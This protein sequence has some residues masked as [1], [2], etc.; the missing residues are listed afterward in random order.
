MRNLILISF[1]LLFGFSQAQT[2][3]FSEDF[4]TLPLSVSSSGS[5]NWARTSMLQHN[6]TYSDSARITGTND[7]TILTTNSFSTS[8]Y[9]HVL[10]TFNHIAKLALF[11]GGYIEVSSNNGTSWT[12]L[13]ASEYYGSGYFGLTGNYRFNS[14][15]YNAIWDP[16][17]NT[18]V[19]Q[20][21]WWRGETFDLSYL[22]P[23]STQAKIR[24]VLAGSTTTNYGWLIDD[25]KVTVSNN[26]LVPP[27]ISL[28]SPYPQDTVYSTGPFDIMANV[29]DSSGVAA[30][31]LVY[32]ISGVS[33][34]IP[35]ILIGGTSYK[36]TIP[37]QSYGTTV[38]WSVIA[39][40][41][42]SNKG[43]NPMGSCISFTTK[44]DPNAPATF[45]YDAAIHSITN[46]QDIVISGTNQNI[47]VRIVNRGDSL[48][49]KATIGWEL[50]G[51]NQSTFTWTGSLS[52]DVSS[53]PFTIGT[54]TYT[55]GNHTIKAF[56]YNPNDSIDQNPS[57]DTLQM[58]F[59]AC[60][61]ILNGIYTL[62]GNNANFVDFADLMMTLV[63]CG[64]SG[65]TTIKVN[66][67]T[68]NEQVMFPDSIIG[69]DSL[70]PLTI[71][72]STNNKNDVIITYAPSS[73]EN[74][75]VG[76]DSVSWINIKDI[77]V[78]SIGTSSATA[79]LMKDNSSNITID[80]C[81]IKSVYGNNYYSKAI[82]IE[83]GSVHDITLSNNKISGGYYAISLYGIYSNHQN[84][85]TI[86]NNDIFDFY[87][88]G[89]DIHYSDYPIIKYNNIHRK[90]DDNNTS[91]NGMYISYAMHLDIESNQIKLVPD[92]ASYGIYISSSSGLAGSEAVIANNMI[93]ISGSSI[94]SS[95]FGLRLSTCSYLGIYYNSIGISAG[96][97]NS[98]TA[99]YLSGSSSGNNIV[100]NNIFAHLNSGLAFYHSA[101]SFS[102]LDYNA[103]YTNGL[104]I[105]KWG[106][107]SGTSVSSSSGITGIRAVTSQDT[108]SIVAD[109]HFYS[110]TN[111]HSYGSSINGAGDVISMIT[112]DI[113]G[114]LRSSSTPD[115]GADEFTISSIDAGALSILSPLPI[116]TQ[117]KVV[118]LKVIIKNYGSASFT[119]T[120]I[121]YSMNG[122][123]PVNYA[124]TGNL[125][126]GQQ[127]TVTLGNITLPAGDYSL[128]VY[129]TLNGDTIN[130]N[131]TVTTIFTAL[132][133]VEVEVS[134][135]VSPADGCGK[136]STEDVTVEITN[137]GV[138][139]IYN[140]LSASF[141]VNNGPVYTESISDTLAPG[142]SLNYTFNQQADLT[143]GYQ[144]ST[145]HFVVSAHHSSDLNNINDTAR[146]DVVSL[147]NLHAPIVSDTTINYGDTVSLTAISNN[148]I[149]WYAND[150]S[151]NTIGSGVYTTPNLFDTTTYYAQANAYNPPQ[152]GVIGT[153]TS[154]F[155]PFDMSPYGANMAAGKYQIL[156]TAAELNAAGL[157]A[158]NIESIAFNVASNFNAPSAGFEVS[159]ANVSISSLTNTFVSTTMTTVVNGTFIGAQGWNT[160]TF[161]TP[162]YWD[163]TSNLLIQ[164]CT[165]GNPYNAAPMYYTTTASTMLTGTQGMG[166]SCTS[167]SGIAKTKRPNIKIKKQGTAGCYSSKVPLTVNVP[168]P[169]IDAT[170]S[171]IVS[172]I[173]NCGLV[174]TQ[175][176][177]DIKNMGTD[178]IKGPF[179][180]TYKIGNAAYVTAE[181]INDTIAPSDTLRY[182]FN[183]LA[184]LAPGANGT[185]YLITAKVNVNSDSYAPNDTLVSDSIFSKYTPANPIV[186]N[187][188]INYGDTTVLTATAN[189]SIYWYAD[190]MGT[191]LVGIGSSFT[192]APIYDTTSFFAQARKT[193]V[194]TN[195]VVGK[196]TATTNYSGPSPYGAGGYSGWGQRNQY[197]ITAA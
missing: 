150:T 8:T 38:C 25:I 148:P 129:T 134:N 65:P 60:P 187:Q 145:F 42:N 103:Y 123:S 36:A 88:H 75:V 161:S 5:S 12:R 94:S 77:T 184:S 182:T 126:S 90:Y 72:S 132:P 119:S 49:T 112:T 101:G 84:R 91:L 190:S 122:A 9:N 142:A 54:K 164:I 170:V 22:I 168:L 7:T 68:Y 156:Y 162:F 99:F 3:K 116:D 130:S 151:S 59:Y 27:T 4:E 31:K 197:L 115:I 146:Y 100:K 76:F 14:T 83:G 113:D 118:A 28:Q 98:T 53:N 71:V 137:N 17:N 178:S 192:T 121:K 29:T 58:S 67:G 102:D 69:I 78:K 152:T 73:T 56:A 85:I 109:P 70:S 89:I 124:W 179:S 181:I 15:S 138:G 13:T 160:H 21:S 167:P 105:M 186:S 47:D 136:G 174:S 133:L 159:V 23:N 157:T 43:Q 95:I 63:N 117:S 108:N 11:D 183:T 39:L 120:N 193:I 87:R 64:M 185:K 125:G 86:T 195:Y 166:T 52:L 196:G 106:G 34:T 97:G 104:I 149:V 1:L 6:G 153:S 189:D 66:P 128:S 30:V 10:L 62:G 194:A 114:E 131:D 2:V 139:Y 173:D 18:T 61:S 155:G 81:S 40:D 188:T 93:S 32:S 169:A 163:G 33:D 51:V 92:A 45:P 50:D 176:T 41:S 180:A 111:L 80:N 158:G 141:Q 154:T 143:T 46:P 135:L 127:D 37:S 172:P 175:V 48:M 20:N 107:Y 16:M 96:S 171:D 191:Q 44:K 144:N 110:P 57:N 26:E 82:R 177:I 165:N 79:I 35:M 19:P 74:Y 24:F 140:G 147:A 55:P